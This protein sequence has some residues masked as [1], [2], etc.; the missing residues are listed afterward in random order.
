MVKRAEADDVPLVIRFGGGLHTRPGPDDIGK[1]EAADGNN[2]TLDYQN[3]QFRSR[4]PFDLIGTV[5]NEQPIRGGV[6]LRR[7]DGSTTMLI[8]AGDTVY[9]WDG[10]TT[11]TSVGTVS[12][13]A[14][15]RGHW[16]K[17]YWALGD[18]VLITDM[19]VAERVMR[20]NGSVL[21]HPT[22][23]DE[24]GGA[25][26]SFFAKY[27]IIAHERALFAN[28]KDATTNPHMMIGS[29][30]SN[31]LQ[32]SVVNAPSTSL[33][34]DDPFF[35]LSP[36]LKSIN[37]LVEAFG[38]TLVSTEGGQLFALS[39][40]SPADYEFSEFYP[41]SGATGQESVCYIGNDVVYGKRGR[42]ESV[43]DTNKF[44]D[45]EFS[46]IAAGI[47][48]AVQDYASWTVIFNQRI[49]RVYCFPAEGSEVWVTDTAMLAAANSAVSTSD[50]AQGANATSP[51]MRWRTRHAM[52]FKPTF[53]MSMLDPIDG[54]EYIFMGDSLGHLYRMEGR[55]EAGD[56]GSEEI[57]AEFLSK[58]FEIPED[59]QAFGFEGY[60]SYEKNEAFTLFISFEFQGETIYTETMTV[61][62]PA[63][64]ERLYFG[65][66][67]YFNG[68]VYFGSPAG[69]LS[70]QPFIAPGQGNAF[71]VRVQVSGVTDFVVNEIGIRFGASSR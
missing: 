56:A 35:L 47:Q 11:F 64:T 31:Y 54:L 44:G 17:H 21:D 68:N 25:L 1:T 16:Q 9:Q 46:N 4:K 52:G 5:P 41:G 39:G 55:G 28:E 7:V 37:G 62:V 27:C 26:G 60:V 23:V 38:T 6:S 49:N 24:V 19:A 69:K 3:K 33:G 63:V 30:T 14:Q 13:S 71:Q 32:L 10:L 70:R 18:L 43:T 45:A 40:T 42:L 22:F 65:G 51:W 15:L 53:V 67:N 57:Q 34:A 2:F 50:A 58:V 12:A 29:K 59:A 8:Q 66:P 36:D 61:N 20:W 48:D